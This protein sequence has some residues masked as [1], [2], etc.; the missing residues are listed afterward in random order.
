MTALVQS[1]IRVR[2]ALPLSEQ[3][4]HG[5]K[6]QSPLLLGRCTDMLTNGTNIVNK[7]IHTYTVYTVFTELPFSF[8]LFYSILIK[9]LKEILDKNRRIS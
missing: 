4:G 7:Y 2:P 1:I 6:Q 9:E 5:D 3:L 8:Q